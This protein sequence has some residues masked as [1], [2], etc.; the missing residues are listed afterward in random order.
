MQIGRKKMGETP[1]LV[2]VIILFL[3]IFLCTNSSF[4]QMI[5]FRGC[6]RDKD[7]PQFRGVNIR[8]R[9]GFCTPIDS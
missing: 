9:S 1:K 6:K 3:S 7:C 5:N 2:Y 8:C 4:S